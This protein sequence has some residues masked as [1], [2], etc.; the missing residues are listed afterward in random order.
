MAHPATSSQ[1]FKSRLDERR[2]LD[3][4]LSSSELEGPANRALSELT[5]AL[6]DENSIEDVWSAGK[7]LR[8][9]I[10][11][12]ALFWLTGAAAYVALH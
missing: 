2:S 4:P 3:V 8:F 9:I 12:C 1:D 11:S 10:V 6:S 7:T 5:L